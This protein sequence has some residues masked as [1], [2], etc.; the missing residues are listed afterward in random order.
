MFLLKVKLEKKNQLDY[1]KIFRS[2][3]KNFL[4]YNL[5]VQLPSS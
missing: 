4:S 5:V 3:K 1:I 2:E